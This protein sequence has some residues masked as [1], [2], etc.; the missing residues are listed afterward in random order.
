MSDKNNRTSYSIY[1]KKKGLV[2]LASTKEMNKSVD[3]FIFSWYQRL[4]F[5]IC[6]KVKGK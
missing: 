2:T 1:D 5:W 6:D 3:K 4:W